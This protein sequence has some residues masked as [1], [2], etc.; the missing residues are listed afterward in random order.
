MTGWWGERGQSLS[1]GQRQA[2][3]LAR[4]LLSN[5]EILVMD[6]PT[7]MMDMQAEKV[8]MEQLRTVLADKTLILIT[9]RPT[10]LSLVDRIII[11]GQGAVVKDESRTQ[12]MNMAQTATAQRAAKIKGQG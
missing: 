1:G 12:V 2:V 3:G 9:H 5:P 7:S 10:L 6:E 11:M 4:A 8:F